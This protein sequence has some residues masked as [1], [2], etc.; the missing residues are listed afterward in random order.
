MAVLALE[1]LKKSFGETA[2]LAGIDLVLGDG[3]MLV[4]VGASGCGKSTLLRLVAVQHRRRQL[5]RPH[6]EFR[7][8]LRS[9]RH[10]ASRARLRHLLLP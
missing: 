8:S 1:G 5:R 10:V 9:R 4:I 7:F 3:E 6:Q 2:V